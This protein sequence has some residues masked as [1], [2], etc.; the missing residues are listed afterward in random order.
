VVTKEHFE[1]P[2]DFSPEKFF[3]SALGVLGG[4]GNFLV[5]IRFKSEVAD[6]VREREWH[7]SQEKRDL[8]DGGL[9]LRLRLGA[10]AEIER[11][12]LG[13]GATAEVVKPAA[14]REKIRATATALAATYVG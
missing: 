8:P 14:L 13:W 11:W 9:E 2:A 10:L 12:V 3:S 7:E 4:D 1:K 5:V 6:L